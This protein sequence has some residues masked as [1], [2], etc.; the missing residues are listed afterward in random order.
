MG[1]LVEAGVVTLSMSRP[2]VS[3]EGGEGPQ[4]GN[5]GASSRDA[6]RFPSECASPDKGRNSKASEYLW[7]IVFTGWV[8]GRA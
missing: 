4:D 7:L 6:P 5:R 1:M 8:L 2:P 3:M